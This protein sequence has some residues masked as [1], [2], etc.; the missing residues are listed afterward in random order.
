MSWRF[1]LLISG[2]NG[3]RAGSDRSQRFTHGKTDV[4]EKDEYGDFVELRGFGPLVM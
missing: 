2:V 3:V 4:G 1:T